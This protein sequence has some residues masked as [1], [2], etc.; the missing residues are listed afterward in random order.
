MNPRDPREFVAA[1]DAMRRAQK[2]YFR[3]RAA[4][5]LRAA[6]TAEARVDLMLSADVVRAA[7][8]AQLALPAHAHASAEPL[9]ESPIPESSLPE[10]VARDLGFT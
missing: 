10:S 8:P 9:P 3:S 6:K 2:A 5:D 7:P 4:S 1:V